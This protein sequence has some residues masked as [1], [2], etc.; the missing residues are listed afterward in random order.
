MKGAD[1]GDASLEMCAPVPVY[2][3]YACKQILRLHSSHV[4]GSQSGGGTKGTIQAGYSA[5]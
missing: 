5:F 3:W 2:A 4:L 1:W